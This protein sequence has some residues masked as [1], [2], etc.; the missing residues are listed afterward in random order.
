MY[1]PSIGTN[2]HSVLSNYYIALVQFCNQLLIPRMLMFFFLL[3]VS[4]LADQSFTASLPCLTSPFRKD[5]IFRLV[6]KTRAEAQK[7]TTL[8]LDPCRYIL[9]E[10]DFIQQNKPTLL[11]TN[12]R[13]RVILANA[14]QTIKL[15][16]RDIPRF[17]ESLPQQKTD[18]QGEYQPAVMSQ[19]YGSHFRERSNWNAT[20]MYIHQDNFYSEFQ[21]LSVLYSRW[22]NL[23]LA[24]PDFVRLEVAGKSVEGRPIYVLFIGRTNPNAPRRL[25]VTALLHAREWVVATVATY[26]AERLALGLEPMLLGVEVVIVPVANPDGYEYTRTGDRFWR[27]NRMIIPYKPPYCA[28]VDL[29]RNWAVDFL[30][31]YSTSDDPCSSV[32]AGAIPFSEPETQALKSLVLL[33]G[34]QAHFDLH[35]YA[36]VIL[37]PYA[38]S[39]L[40]PPKVNDVIDMGY[41]IAY[42]ITDTFNVSYTFSYGANNDL[43]AASGIMM[44]WVHS[45]GVLSF[46][47][48]VRPKIRNT[49]RPGFLL[50][51]EEILP[52]CIEV[53]RGMIALLEYARRDIDEIELRQWLEDM[54]LQDK[55]TNDVPS[56]S[57]EEVI[58]SPSGQTSVAAI[59]GIVVTGCA[60]LISFVCVCAY[61]IF[62][63]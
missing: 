2:C 38:H 23:S 36:R 55:L 26:F 62:S 15:H 30:G 52:T 49:G 44:D 1:C 12:P 33:P 50:P 11:I 32:F 6:P 57:T 56:P 10:P 48:E 59:V 42:H 9:I 13:N 7:L 21:S 29:N 43:Y 63:R 41:K 3:T 27:K 51:T 17:L 22:L 53:Y 61:C 35:A 31:Q 19:P 60:L 25:L 14:T 39:H 58:S 47:A 40:R 34:M 28:G 45:M 54:L 4:I 24:Y 18:Y 37:G 46:T 16:I 20:L 5:S 8:L